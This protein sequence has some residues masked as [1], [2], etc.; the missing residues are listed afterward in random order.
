MLAWTD[1][2]VGADP[3]ADTCHSELRDLTAKSGDTLSLALGVAGRMTALCTNYGKPAEAVAS[4][5]DLAAMIDRVDA[6]PMLK[7][8]LLFTVMWAQFLVCDYDALFTTAERIRTIA[9][10]D[11]NS[12]VARA[13]AVCGTSRI[14]TGDAAAGQR[15][16]AVGIEQARDTDAVTFA[17]VMTLKCCLTAVGLEPP[18]TSALDDAYESLRR[19]EAYGDNFATACAHWACGTVLLRLDPNSESA[20]VEHLKSARDIITKHRTV[21]VALAPI[22][23]DLALITARDGDVD[24]AIESMRTVIG[25]QLENFDVTFMGVTI[26]ASISYWSREAARTTSPRRP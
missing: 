17:A 12:S 7:V 19:A 18:T 5:A 16:L 24:G 21:V 1:W 15:E 10:T 14:V 13:T 23:A 6:D 2:L 3:D 20:A 4:A 8:D 11:V 22:E 25:R 26:P 9:G